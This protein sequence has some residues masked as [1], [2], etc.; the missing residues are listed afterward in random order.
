[1]L[2]RVFLLDTR[3]CA[4]TLRMMPFQAYAR[5][6]RRDGSSP[7][8]GCA[9]DGTTG[10]GRAC[11]ARSAERSVSR[12][13][14]GGAEQRSNLRGGRRVARSIRY[15]SPFLCY[16]DACSPSQLPSLYR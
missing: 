6:P 10:Q 14:R 4:I 3:K 5:E 11:G 2:K 13:G 7:H 16:I 9:P 1:M 12:S 8:G 15:A